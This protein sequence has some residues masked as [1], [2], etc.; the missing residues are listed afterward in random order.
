MIWQKC[1]HWRKIELEFPWG[2]GTQS[3][4]GISNQSWQKNGNTARFVVGFS[5]VWC[6]F[7][8]RRH[9]RPKYGDAAPLFPAAGRDGDGDCTAGLIEKKL[10][11]EQKKDGVCFP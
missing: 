5:L 3:L 2:T 9:G 7:V 11:G 1:R 6:A 10:R 4:H 8:S